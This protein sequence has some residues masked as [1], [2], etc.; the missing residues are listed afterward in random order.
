MVSVLR[1]SAGRRNQ[2]LSGN[3]SREWRDNVEHATQLQQSSVCPFTVSVHEW[4]D[5][6][7]IDDSPT[8]NR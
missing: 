6:R 5:S 1:I 3:I 4:L 7:W 2:L 8:G